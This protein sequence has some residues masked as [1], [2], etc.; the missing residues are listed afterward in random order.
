MKFRWDFD[1]PTM[2]DWGIGLGLWTNLK[3]GWMSFHQQR[4]C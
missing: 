4:Y 3:V 1:H 2:N